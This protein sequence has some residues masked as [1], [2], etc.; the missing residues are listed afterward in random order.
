M[1][2]LAT[3]H[4]AMLALSRQALCR[5]RNHRTLG[6]LGSAGLPAWY[7]RTGLACDVASSRARAKKGELLQPI[8][9]TDAGIH[10]IYQHTKRSNRRLSSPVTLALD[11]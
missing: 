3:M 9:S 7:S 5:L 11:E 6:N 4:W 8:V 1:Q 2:W 10:A